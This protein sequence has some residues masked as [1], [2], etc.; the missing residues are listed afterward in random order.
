[1]P[2][3][4]RSL[5]VVAALA[6]ACAIAAPVARAGILVEGAL[7]GT[8]LRA[9]LGRDRARVLVTVAGRPRLVDLATGRIWVASDGTARPV[10]AALAD[11]GVRQQA[12]RLE[13][14]SRGPA[15]AGYAS[16]YNVLQLG[17]SICAEVLASRWMTEFVEPVVQAI[18]LL[19]RIEPALRPKP[20]PGCGAVPFEVYARNG[21]P[22]MAGYRDAAIFRTESIRF[23]HAVDPARFRPDGEVANGGAGS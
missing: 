12:W 14:W 20:R 18:S 21:W 8:P 16:T 9:E 17:E 13:Q 5:T 1:M 3:D 10:A 7:E 19:Q 2:R 4:R 23:D 6:C 11:D 22:L 15:V